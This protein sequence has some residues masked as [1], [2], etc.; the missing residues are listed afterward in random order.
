MI[1]A[2]SPL[3]S[4]LTV[5]L[6]FFNK[7][8]KDELELCSKYLNFD[9]NIIELG[10]SIGV[11]ASHIKERLKGGKMICVEANPPL[12]SL[13]ERTFSINDFNNI[14]LLNVAVSDSKEPVYFSN[15]GSNE[16]GK[17]AE[18]AAL[19]VN[20]LAL[21]DIISQHSIGKF[22][23]VSDIEGAEASFILS[24]GL[25]NCEFAIIE[26]HQVKWNGTSY[27]IE[28]LKELIVQQGFEVVAQRNCTFAFRRVADHG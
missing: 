20:T 11:V 12:H 26:L 22:D 24:G 21:E 6:I 16:L 19:K 10:T 15:R 2:D 8:E 27:A 5:A 1:S 23:L 17:I 25:E 7:Y 9:S 14:T 3:V 18:H 4:H 13:I 28:E